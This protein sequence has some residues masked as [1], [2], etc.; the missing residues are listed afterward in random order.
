MTII[1]T[2]YQYLTFIDFYIG[3]PKIRINFVRPDPDLVFRGSDPGF[4][5]RSDPT[6]AFERWSDPGQLHP[7]IY[8][9]F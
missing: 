8:Q 9:Q 7:G 3:K 5:C 2:K 4:S 6:S 1:K